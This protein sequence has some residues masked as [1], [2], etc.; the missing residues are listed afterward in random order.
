M[1]SVQ[2]G[3]TK[4]DLP[5]HIK[6]F[7]ENAPIEGPKT[8]I[9]VSEI[10]KRAKQLTIDSV[11]AKHAGEYTCV[12]ENSAGSRMRSAVLSVNGIPQKSNPKLLVEKIPW[13]SAM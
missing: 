13:L 2:C 8:D 12:A 9:V 5:L 10:G 7:F 11:A 4:G 3:V 6:W 1:A